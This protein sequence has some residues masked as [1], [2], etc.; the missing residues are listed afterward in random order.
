MDIYTAPKRK[1]KGFTFLFLWIVCLISTVLIITLNPSPDTLTRII[2]MAAFGGAII[3]LP[4]WGFLIG[5]K[6]VKI[7]S[8]LPVSLV[9]LFLIC[10]LFILRPHKITGWSMAPNFDSGEYVLSEKVSY[11]FNSPKRGDV[12]IF[13]R[14][15]IAG[16]FVDRIIGLPGEKISIK[17]GH[18]YIN[19]KILDEPYVSGNTKSNSSVFIDENNM[20]IPDGNVVV[21]GD[22]R[23]RSDDSR[24]YGF[25]QFKDIT[26]RMFYVYW[27]KSKSGLIKNPL[28][29]N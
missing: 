22:N 15:D 27:P 1:K 12:I 25:I 7:L 11:Y 28:V 4:I 17:D 21:M 8:V 16:D 23:G 20:L 26:G 2:G 29:Y 14:P 9:T 6:L 19:N 13:K 5:N 10:Y 18:V 24:D 3:F